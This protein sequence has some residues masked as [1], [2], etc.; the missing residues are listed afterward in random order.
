MK[1]TNGQTQ[2]PIISE[3]IPAYNVTKCIFFL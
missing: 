1:N 2:K 3:R